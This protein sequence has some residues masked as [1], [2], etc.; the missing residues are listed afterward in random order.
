MHTHNAFNGQCDNTV[1]SL[2]VLVCVLEDVA[3]ERVE[4]HIVALYFG[5]IC[6]ERHSSL[7]EIVGGHCHI[8]RKRGNLLQKF[9]DHCQKKENNFTFK[10]LKMCLILKRTS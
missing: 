3:L 4:R 9:F 1:A 10:N 2:R 7:F 8:Q 5:E 6:A